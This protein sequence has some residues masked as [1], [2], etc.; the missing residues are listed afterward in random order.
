MEFFF[1]LP[2]KEIFLA[3]D[4]FHPPDLPIHQA[5]LDAVRVCGVNENRPLFPAF[6][7]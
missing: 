7:N 5:D 3:D 2:S 4:L 6:L 1:N